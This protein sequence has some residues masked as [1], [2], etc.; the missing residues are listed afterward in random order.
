VVGGFLNKQTADD[1]GISE[2]TI[3]VHRSQIMRKMAA[4][5]LAE[6]VRMAD[7]MGIRPHGS[8]TK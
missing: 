4:R 5:S 2:V 7:K 6:L 8:T 1:L 3:G